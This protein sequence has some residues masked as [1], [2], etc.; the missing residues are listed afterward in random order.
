MLHNAIQDMPYLAA[1]N[2]FGAA[3][4]V[5]KLVLK[6]RWIGLEYEAEKLLASLSEG[7]VGAIAPSDTD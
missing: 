6:L 7:E 3:N 4:D 2:D 5:R 1:A